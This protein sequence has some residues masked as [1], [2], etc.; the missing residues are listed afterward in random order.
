VLDF[1]RRLISE[2]TDATILILNRSMSALTGPI[3]SL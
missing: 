2:H 3:L 1:I